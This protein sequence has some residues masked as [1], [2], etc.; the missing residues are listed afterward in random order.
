MK[1][2]ALT[3]SLS[4]GMLALTAW[5]SASRA[6]T[7]DQP[8][9]GAPYSAPALYN[10]GNSYARAGQPA[11]A[12]LSYERAR[13]LAPMDPDIRA[14]LAHVRESAGLSFNPDSWWSPHDRLADANTM[15]WVGLF[16]LALAG[17]GFL[18]RRLRADHRTAL[19]A[20]AIAGLV[21]TTLSLCDAIATAS[22]LNE[23]VV[24]RTAPASASPISGA[25]PLFTVPQAEVVI[26]RD[27]HQGFWLIRDPQ[28]RE[29]WVARND[30]T[31][32]IPIA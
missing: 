26:V 31:P 18:L 5:S 19:T 23:S 25:E 11:L 22:V 7:A 13:L 2:L 14:N 28:G 9:M 30:L 4:V 20:M 17:A 10:L 1:T 29:G 3:I 21:L 12:V 16:G 6:A 15:Y 27:A 24:M 8:G 32:I